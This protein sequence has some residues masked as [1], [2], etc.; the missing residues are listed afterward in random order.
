MP[1][2]PVPRRNDTTGRGTPAAVPRPARVLGAVAAALV[3]LSLAN[4]AATVRA[5]GTLS[6]GNVTP[7]SGTT[8]TSFGFSVHYTSTGSPSQP[9]GAVSAQVGSVTVPLT[10]V[11]GSANDGTWEGSSTLPAGTWQVTFIAVTSDPQPDPLLARFVTVTGPPPPTPTPQPTAPPTPV[12][13][14][15]PQPTSPP[16]PFPTPRPAPQPTQPPSADDDPTQAPSPSP[17]PSPTATGS[18]RPRTST[19]TPSPTAEPDDDASPTPEAAAADEGPASP[20]G[21]SL[22]SFLVVGGTMSLA[23]AAVLARQ[24]Y[25]TRRAGSPH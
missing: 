13:T 9:A 17:S 15:P 24:W 2:H 4:P 20:P 23:G 1:A 3:V 8:A 16:G 21:S 19:P 5:A 12:P 10:R 11:S 7:T 18:A 25:V 22:A 14:A 6:A